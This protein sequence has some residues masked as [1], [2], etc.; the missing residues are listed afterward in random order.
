MVTVL[1]CTMA[2]KWIKKTV[3]KKVITKKAQVDSLGG[4]KLWAGRVHEAIRLFRGQNGNRERTNS[5]SS[6]AVALMQ[7]ET[8]MV[9]LKGSVMNKGT[10]LKG[11]EVT[12]ST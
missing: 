10:V 3:F 12:K 1:D 2:V 7:S 6:E 4:V 5:V 8:S 11:N 9:G